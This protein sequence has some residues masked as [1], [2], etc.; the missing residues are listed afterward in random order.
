MEPEGMALPMTAFERQ[1]PDEQ[2]TFERIMHACE[3][4]VLRVALRLLRN[5]QDAQDAAQEV[6]LRLYRNLGRLDEIHGYEAWLFRVTVN[7]C[8]DIGRRRRHTAV[9]EDV[10][11]PQADAFHN[12]ARAEQ[13][14]MLRRG[15]T[16]LGPKERA[17]LV[18]RDVEG[19]STREVAGIL[20]TSETTVRAQIST[21]RLKLREFTRRLSRRRS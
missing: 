14:E 3:R 18:L 7:V 21:A 5:P 6:F 1:R 10:A 2:A 19:L 15:L 12:A 17:A 13:R 4:R 20:G 16:F 11:S 8:R 9:L